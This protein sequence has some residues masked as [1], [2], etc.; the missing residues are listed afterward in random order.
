MINYGLEEK[1]FR[2]L[3]KYIHAF[4]SRAYTG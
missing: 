3:K 2:V 4:H 1:Y